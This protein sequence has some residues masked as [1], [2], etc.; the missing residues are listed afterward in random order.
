ML[1]RTKKRRNQDTA[2]KPITTRSPW[3][4][5]V[6]GR[7]RSSLA[8]GVKRVGQREQPRRENG[9]VASQE[10]NRA[11]SRGPAEEQPA[12]MW[13]PDR[14][15]PGTSARHC[16]SADDDAVFPRELFDV[17]VLLAVVLGGGR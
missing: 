1:W 13:R 11:E 14:D 12:L 10:P 8:N 5:T 16:A 3:P 9:G 7:W 6:A 15:T 2:R 4:P 17:L